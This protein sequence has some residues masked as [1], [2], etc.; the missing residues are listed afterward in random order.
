MHSYSLVSAGTGFGTP[1]KPKPIDAQV[2]Y[3]KQNTIYAYNLYTSS[4]VL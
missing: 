1:G 3:A 4:H 2:P